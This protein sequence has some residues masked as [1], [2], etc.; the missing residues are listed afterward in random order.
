MINRG[1][2]RMN[3]LHRREREV[4]CERCRGAR[5][6]GVAETGDELF[7]MI[8]FRCQGK[9]TVIETDYGFYHEEDSEEIG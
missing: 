7:L 5:I 6:L 9:G 1:E 4:V 3:Y 8:C 2:E